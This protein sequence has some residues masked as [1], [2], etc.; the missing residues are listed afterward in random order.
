MG[1]LQ[2]SICMYVLIQVMINRLHSLL[3]FNVRIIKYLA[4]QIVCPDCSAKC[5]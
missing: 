2:C 5:I 3:F 1:F 4:H